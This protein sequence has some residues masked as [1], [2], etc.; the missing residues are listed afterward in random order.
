MDCEI[1]QRIQTSLLTVGSNLSWSCGHL[2]ATFERTDNSQ[3]QHGRSVLL[4][5]VTCVN[6]IS[7][8]TD[9]ATVAVADDLHHGHRPPPPP[10][11]R[12]RLFEGGGGD[13]QSYHRSSIARPSTP[14]LLLLLS[15]AG[16]NQHSS[17]IVVRC[18]RQW[19]WRR[20]RSG[21]D[22]HAPVMSCHA[23]SREGG[24][25]LSV[26]RHARDRR[27]QNNRLY[28]WQLASSR[29]SRAYHRITSRLAAAATNAV[30]P[31]DVD[32]DGI[33][34]PTDL[35]P[36]HFPSVRNTTMLNGPQILTVC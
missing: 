21:G 36:P 19:W 32:D 4:P 23:R 8:S 7:A 13:A 34:M 1:P 15:S 2:L 28:A 25:G 17:Q 24:R 30:R 18:R 16:R 9:I 14:L 27:L 12:R 31:S 3:Y 26:C 35:C 33:H 20:Q 22:N 29:S 10:S 11:R 6:S 5:G